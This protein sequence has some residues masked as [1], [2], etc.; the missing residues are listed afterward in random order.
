MSHAAS[1]GMLLV[2]SGSYEQVV[3]D[4]HSGQT[5]VR[6]EITPNEYCVPDGLCLMVSIFDT[7]LKQ[8]E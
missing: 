7:T 5:K 4:R 8:P 6:K 1:G 2:R 3:M